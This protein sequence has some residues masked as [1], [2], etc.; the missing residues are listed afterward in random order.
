MCA[1][2]NARTPP[3]GDSK[4]DPHMAVAPSPDNALAS[5]CMVWPCTLEKLDICVHSVDPGSRV[6]T[7]A[8]LFAEKMVN[9]LLSIAAPPPTMSGFPLVSV[10]FS[11]AV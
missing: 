7:A 6:N 1:S 11:A 2:E 3:E 8:E 10:A 5:V 9:P 4:R